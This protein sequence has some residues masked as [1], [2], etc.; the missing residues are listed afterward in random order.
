MAENKTVDKEKYLDEIE[1]SMNHGR[2]KSNSYNRCIDKW[3]RC[4]GNERSNPCGSKTC[5]CKRT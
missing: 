1:D 5:T 4:S 3:R 2:Q